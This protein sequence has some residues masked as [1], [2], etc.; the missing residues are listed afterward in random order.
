[1]RRHSSGILA[2]ITMVLAGLTIGAGPD[3]AL[4]KALEGIEPERV[5]EHIKVLASDELEGR[6]PG[7]A[8]ELKTIAYLTDQFRRMGLKPGNPDGTYVQ[9][10]PLV[11]FR[12][13]RVDG[14]FLT[15]GGPSSL[16]FPAD[17]VA[18]SRR[19]TPEAK[20]ADAEAVFVGYGVV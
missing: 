15:R 10:V 16:P 9:D 18:V 11:G 5:L 3:S 6:G 2:P 13:T 17:F 4:E 19:M 8:G 14:A 12:A 1:M 20:V 7:T